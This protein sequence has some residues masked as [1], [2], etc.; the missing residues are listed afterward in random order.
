M[1]MFIVFFTPLFIIGG[2]WSIMFVGF[3]FAVLIALTENENDFWALTVIA[4]FGWCFIFYNPTFTLPSLT[5]ALTYFAVYFVVGGL[6]SIGKWFFF[7]REKA[8]QFGQVK[9]RFF[10]NLN[11]IIPSIR[12]EV[13]FVFLFEFIHLK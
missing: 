13:L 4:L 3:L 5:T 8:Y 9:V 12:R 10:N 1:E 2:L 11:K 6:W 7:V